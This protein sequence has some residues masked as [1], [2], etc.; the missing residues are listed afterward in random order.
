MI[1]D[2]PLK[3]CFVLVKNYKCGTERTA[4]ANGQT[5]NAGQLLL[6]ANP[7]PSA[8]LLVNTHC[9]YYL[10]AWPYLLTLTVICGHLP[11]ETSTFYFMVKGYLVYEG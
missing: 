3:I 5:E 11:L 8:Q 6:S 9:E 1:D 2:I 4:D 7:E 10:E